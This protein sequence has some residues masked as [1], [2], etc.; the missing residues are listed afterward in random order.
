[1]SYFAP[2]LPTDKHC[3]FGREGGV[4]KGIYQG[5][6]LHFRGGD[7]PENVKK[8]MEIVASYFG[9][10]AQNLLM[11]DQGVSNKCI[12]ATKPSLYQ[13][14]ADGAVTDVKDL[15]LCIRTADCAP[16]LMG[17]FENG[18]IGAAHAGWRGAFGGI[19]ENTL[20]MM[21][22]KGAKLENICAGVGPCIGQKSYEVDEGFYQQFLAQNSKNRQ[23]FIPSVNESHYQ[24]D[25]EKYC[26]DKLWA[27][28]V[29]NVS[30]SGLDTYAL[31]DQYYSFRRYTHLGLIKAPKCFPV[32]VSTIVLPR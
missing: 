19:I 7:N 24:F 27:Y 17:D 16:V 31:C 28:G 4:S 25:L 23:Y 1:M 29:K 5:L 15:I 2:N 3:F 22:A 8:N 9:L 32:E 18:I 13:I 14:E 6:N 21:L 20:D 11:L 10:T 26:V 12:Y 30:A